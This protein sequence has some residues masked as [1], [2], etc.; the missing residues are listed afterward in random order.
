MTAKQIANIVTY[1]VF[2]NIAINKGDFNIFGM[3][4]FFNH[5]N[6]HQNCVNLNLD[7]NLHYLPIQRIITIKDIQ[8]GEELFISYGGNQ[9]ESDQRQIEN[10]YGIP[11][12]RF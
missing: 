8:K 6:L 9:N 7:K 5:S 11:P 12:E 1:N 2:G 4:S 10:T 3:Q